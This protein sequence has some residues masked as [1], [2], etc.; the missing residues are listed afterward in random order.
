MLS[1]VGHA[2]AGSTPPVKS[3]PFPESVRVV[4]LGPSPWPRQT[5][6]GSP[7][8]GAPP[9]QQDDERTIPLAPVQSATLSRT[10]S[11]TAGPAHDAVRVAVL[12][13]ELAVSRSREAALSSQLAAALAVG[14][15][16][17][18]P[19]SSPSMQR[20]IPDGACPIGSCR[21]LPSRCLVTSKLHLQRSM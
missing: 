13:G 20:L 6:L 19:L 12:S 9:L 15:S 10:L 1:P 8:P 7:S 3:P 5:M 4:E 11:P 18:L 14:S 16:P 17:P 21:H 2:G